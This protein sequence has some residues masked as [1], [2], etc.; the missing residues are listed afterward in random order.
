MS[1]SS[2]ELQLVVLPADVK[3]MF[4]PGE[5]FLYADL[6]DGSITILV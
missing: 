1:N 2:E 5:F 3:T 4:A 6:W